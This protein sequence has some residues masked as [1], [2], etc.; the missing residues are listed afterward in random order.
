MSPPTPDYP[1]IIIDTASRKTWVGLKL[2]A[3]HLDYRFEDQDPSKT[4]FR[5][6]DA[7]LV[8]AR[9]TL[10][11][12]A[13]MA[14]CVGPGSML[15][16]RTACMAIRTWKGIGIA[17]AQNVFS[18]S[19]LEVGALLAAAADESPNQGLVLTDARRSSWNALAYPLEEKG[20]MTLLPNEDL[21]SIASSCVTFA[22]FPN[23]TQATVALISLS[24][25][26]TPIFAGEAFLP[27]LTPTPDATPLTLR[28]NEFKKWEAKIHSAPPV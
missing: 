27:L 16:A 6:V 25:D 9:L 5:L 3:D 26:P 28:S 18:Y 17:A 8:E 19:S 20:G 11:D 23:W 7:L 1:L 21:P 10:S 13:A 22:E 4:L 14:L 15:G 12:L 24:Y 2:A